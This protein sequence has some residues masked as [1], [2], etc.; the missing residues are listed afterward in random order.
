MEEDA[1]WT[2]APEAAAALLQHDWPGNVRE[3]RNRLRRACLMSDPT[4]R[5][6]TAQDLG[7]AELPSSQR[8]LADAVEEFKT[9]L[10][11]ETVAR[12]DGNRTEA[13]KRLD[14]DPRTIYR[15]LNR[16]N[17]RQSP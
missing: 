2:L 14:I 9:R 12:A 11:R 13:A 10:I 17:T 4:D 3:L 1:P 6:L 5:M 7:L 8:S 15:H 16:L